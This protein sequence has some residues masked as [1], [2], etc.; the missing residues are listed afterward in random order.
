[1]AEGE[2]EL[3]LSPWLSVHHKDDLPGRGGSLGKAIG[4]GSRS[5]WL[6]SNP[7]QGV[8]A[9]QGRVSPLSQIPSPQNQGWSGQWR[10]ARG[11][12]ERPAVSK[13]LGQGTEAR[14][15]QD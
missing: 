4:G 1:M 15:E 6:G 12:S 14:K 3:T 10:G 9:R 7:K 5:E 13:H 2:D 8:A 11:Q